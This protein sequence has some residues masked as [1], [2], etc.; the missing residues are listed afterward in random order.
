[1]KILK[2]TFDIVSP[3]DH[4]E[5]YCAAHGEHPFS[6]P[7]EIPETHWKTLT[8]YAVAAGDTLQLLAQWADA[9]KMAT[10]GT[11]LVRNVLLSKAEIGEWHA[12][13]LPHPGAQQIP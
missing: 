10:G 7:H 9:A 11:E 8:S 3:K 2:L 4:P 12:A 13:R 6:K 5:H 1:M